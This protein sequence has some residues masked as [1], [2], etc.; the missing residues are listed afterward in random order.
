MK[1]NL[2]LKSDYKNILINKITRLGYNTSNLNSLEKASLSYFNLMRKLIPITPRKVLK[3][4][5]FNCPNE[6][7]PGLQNIIN[8]LEKGQ[9]LTPH[10]SR[11]LIN[12]EYNDGLLNDWKIH[13]LHLGMSVE[14]DGFVQRTGPLLFGKFDDKNAYLINVMPHGS[15][16]KKEMIQCLHENWSDSISDARL[17]DDTKLVHPPTEHQIKQMRKH[18]VISAIELDDGT[19]YFPIGGGITT[20]GVSIEVVTQH[21]YYYNRIVKLEIAIENNIQNILD[22][23]KEIEQPINFRLKLKNNSFIVYEEKTNKVIITG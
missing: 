14:N 12:L 19:C 2:Y 5:N 21:A 7:I 10:L 1:P 18:G 13:H 3:S 8:K 15:W 17:S 20:S 9:D 23:L 4:K 22:N 6:F 11:Q 16:E